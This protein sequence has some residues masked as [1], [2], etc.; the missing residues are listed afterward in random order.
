MR[1]AR[2]LAR[3][4]SA[5]GKS[6]GRSPD[7]GAATRRPR[8]PGRAAPPGPRTRAARCTMPGRW[9][10]ISF[11]IF[12]ASTMQMT[13]PTAT[14]CADL[15]QH[16]QHGALH[17]RDDGVRLRRGRP[18]GRRRARRRGRRA[19]RAGPAAGLGSRARTG[20][21]PSAGRSTSATSRRS[22]T[23][24]GLRRRLG[25][26]RRRRAVGRRHRGGASRSAGA[27]SSWQAPP[28]MNSSCSNR[29]RWNGIRVA[30]PSTTY[31]SSARIM[32]RRAVSRST[33]CT[34]SLAII[35]S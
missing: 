26:G 31:S 7:R 3:H 17:R 34:M 32:R 4:R 30:G 5:G 23:R 19:R 18:T 13:S 33:S 24:L 22:T 10:A 1:H 11:S 8:S 27:S 20:A 9:A 16:A 35:G 29:Q 28:A 25:R 21:P 6:P 15:D 14:S 2:P 12:I